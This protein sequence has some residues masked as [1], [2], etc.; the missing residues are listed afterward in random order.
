MRVALP[1]STREACGMLAADPSL[2]PLAGATDLLV[3]WP[4]NLDAQERSYLDLSALPDLR[5]IRWS[6]STLTLGA[7]TT[8]WDTINDQQINEHFP[9]LPAAAR[10]VGAIQIQS[11]GTWA[12]NIINASPAAD[13]VPAL[14]ALDAVV[15]LTSNSGD[16]RVPLADFY[17]GY[18]ELRR[19]PDQLITAIEI[20]R[21][22]HDYSVFEKV[23]ARRAQAI[24][25][26]GMAIV[27]SG[28]GWRVAAN[29]VAPTVVRCRAIEALL[30]SGGRASSPTDFLAAARQDIAPIDDIRSTREYRET[31]FCRVLYHALKGKCPGVT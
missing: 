3:H 29:S 21:R 18:K 20:P 19:R 13:G 30:D 31:V 15:V 24:T 4:T 5:A 28:R 11:R 8:Y 16:E 22:A 12:G 26:V 27:H 1:T 25:K 2:I 7:L 9:L 17:L 6:N 10:T 14:M 23:G